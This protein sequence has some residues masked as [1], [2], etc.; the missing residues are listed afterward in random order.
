MQFLLDLHY[1]IALHRAIGALVHS[2][3]VAKTLV[4]ALKDL[5]YY[6]VDSMCPCATYLNLIII[7]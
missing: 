2:S 5:W 6:P 3:K 7:V 4:D 1:D